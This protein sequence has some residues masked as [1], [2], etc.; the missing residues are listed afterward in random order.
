MGGAIAQRRDMIQD[1]EATDCASDEG[2]WLAI[3]RYQPTRK[4]PF[5]IYLRRMVYCRL[6]TWA[7][8]QREKG[9]YSREGIR[10]AKNIPQKHGLVKA[11][12]KAT[13]DVLTSDAV[14]FWEKLKQWTTPEQWSVL[15]GVFRGGYTQAEMAKRL[16][17][18]KQNV[19]NWYHLGLKRL[20]EVREQ[21]AAAA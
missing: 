1:P 6:M 9:G 2:L 20:Y 14:V 8:E 16:G 10:A 11:R 21:V 5:A 7:G 3:E 19:H 17:V 12:H 4:I 13:F 18:S 15:D